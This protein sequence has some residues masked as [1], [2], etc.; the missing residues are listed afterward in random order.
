MWKTFLVS[1]WRFIVVENSEKE[2]VIHR[3]KQGKNFEQIENSRIYPP[4]CGKLIHTRVGK[5]KL[6]TIGRF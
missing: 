4:G 3:Q 6:A 1:F 2:R 5:W